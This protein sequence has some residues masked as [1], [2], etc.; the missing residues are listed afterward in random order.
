[1]ILLKICV[2]QEIFVILLCIYINIIQVSTGLIRAC[3]YWLTSIWTVLASQYWPRP[4][5]HIGHGTT[6]LL[7][8]T[9]AVLTISTGINGDDNALVVLTEYYLP[10]PFSNGL[11]RPC[12]YWL[13]STGIERE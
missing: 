3:H 9:G 7:L 10:V 13:T 4:E 12:H 1:M 8:D 5:F 11:I 6:P 2:C